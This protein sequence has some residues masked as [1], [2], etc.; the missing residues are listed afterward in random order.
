M[1]TNLA[2]SYIQEARVAYARLA[3]SWFHFGKA[4]HKIKSENAFKVDYENFKDFCI[5]EYPDLNYSGLFKLVSVVDRYH[6]EIQKQ[7]ED[8][9]EEW[10]LPPYESFYL[11]LSAEKKAPGDNRISQI[12]DMVLSGSL[13]CSQ[14]RNEI[15]K[16][17]VLED[18]RE[19]RHIEDL[20]DDLYEEISDKDE[21]F[22]D[23]EA[24]EIIDG[25]IEEIIHV[26]A[27]QQRVAYLTENFDGLTNSLLKGV[28]D[29]EKL[30]E[31]L[32][33][34]EGLREKMDTF[35]EEAQRVLE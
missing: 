9:G 34:L 22:D 28:L 33:D 35:I 14:V 32:S 26:S 5:N 11:V 4:V 29:G 1:E 15:K 13:T 18:N 30:E 7:I 17:I 6:D 10:S 19:H 31:F 23:E 20:S 12:K 3:Q 16:T 25:E 27:L 8:E 21:D 24:E 2:K